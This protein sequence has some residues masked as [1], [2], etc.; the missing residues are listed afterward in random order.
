MRAFSLLRQARIL[1]AI[2]MP[3]FVVPVFALDLE[4]TYTSDDNV[5]RGGYGYTYRDSITAVTI[6][7]TYRKSTGQ[8][9]QL[10]YRLSAALEKYARY[11]KLSGATVGLDGA[12]QYRSSSAFTAPTYSLLGKVHAENVQSGLRSGV[13]LEAGASVLKP[14]TD[15]IAVTALITAR[16]RDAA[17][18]VFDTASTSAR[19]NL[20]YLVNRRS[21]LYLTYNR[22]QGDMTLSAPNGAYSGYEVWQTDDA[23]AAGWWAYRFDATTDVA[24]LGYN[25]MLSEKSSID[26]SVMS[27]NSKV[28]AGPSYKSTVVSLAWLKRF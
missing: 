14:L 1:I 27:A 28:Y 4:V 10:V 25:F 21:T 13:S 16:Q 12:W 15:R 19:I 9:S 22:I 20:D 6:G 11:D 26:A 7:Q 24:T 3:G 8:K 18:P 2:L 5:N 17:S 23:F